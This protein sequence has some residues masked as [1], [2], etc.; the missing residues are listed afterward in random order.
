MGVDLLFVFPMCEGSV[1]CIVC[2]KLRD[3]WKNLL[4]FCPEEQE[5]RVMSNQCHCKVGNLQ[6]RKSQIKK[7]PHS[8]YQF[9]QD[10]GLPFKYA[11]ARQKAKQFGLK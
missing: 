5:D 3:L 2:I 4:C 1:L 11:Y 8:V 10:S 9:F 6:K 7:T